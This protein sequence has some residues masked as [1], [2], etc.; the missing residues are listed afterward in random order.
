[1]NTKTLAIIVVFSALSIALSLSPLKFPA[2]YA[3]FLYYQLWEIPIVIA[4]LLYGTKV[5]LSVPSLNVLVLFVFFPGNLPAGP[6][7]NFIAIVSMLLG[8]YLIQRTVGNRFSRGRE[9]ILTA[10]STTLGVVT[11]VTVMS[12]VN[13]IV[14]PMDFPF[15]YTVPPDLLPETVATVAIFN[16]TIVLY[17]IPLAYIIARAI[18]TRTKTQFWKQQ[19]LEA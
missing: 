13:W 18:G 16:A 19:S 2:P 15:G 1:M 10:L 4:F 7:Y 17:T 8:V 3:P 9:I 11:R 5:G 6:I 14:L 12:S